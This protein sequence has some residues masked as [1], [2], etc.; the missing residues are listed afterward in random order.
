MATLLIIDDEAIGESLA[1]AFRHQDYEV[2]LAHTGSEARGRLEQRLFDIIVC[3]ITLPDANGVELLEFVRQV[4]PDSVFLL[5]TGKEHP[6]ELIIQALNLG[7]DRYIVKS[8]RTVE[9][10][11]S[12]VR[13]AEE[14]LRTRRERDLYRRAAREL[15][16]DNIIGQSRLMRAVLETARA[17]APTNSTILITGESGTGKELVARRVHELSLRFDHP[18]VS[19]NCGAFPETLLES[20]LFG[21][22]KGAFTG[23]TQNKQGL[24]QAAGG[25]TLFLD[26]IGEMSLPMQ[27]KLLRVL[28]ERTVR[29][30]GTTEEE[31]VDVRVIAATNKDLRQLVAEKMF[32]ED[33]YYRIS[34]IPL[35]VPPLRERPEDIPLLAL[36]FLQRYSEQMG[37]PVRSLSEEALEALR[38]YLWPGNVRE[39]ENAMERAM[40]LEAG[41]EISLRSLPEHISRV[42]APGPGATLLP[43]GGI[44]LEKHIQEQERA[45]LLAAL[46]CAQGVRTKA[47]E[48]LG[49]SYRSFR[50]YAKKYKI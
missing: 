19:L 6:Q 17:V 47:A 14:Y 45:Y 37:K 23:A 48:L 13:R 40:A 3:D 29:P 12:V 5:M 22:M 25:G 27:V 7:A 21:Y 11:Q 42:S 31:R 8:D 41:E 10:V 32:R 49:M 24:F 1:V 9:E 38:H 26:E 44:N 34:V 39:L 36:H 46:E 4:S 2:A 16:R 43:D 18:F 33:L 15:A 20:E 50:H 35:H 28:Q 30:L